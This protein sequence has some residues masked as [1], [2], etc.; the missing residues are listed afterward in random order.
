MR[1]WKE[2]RSYLKD[3][4]NAENQ[5]RKLDMRR[6]KRERDELMEIQRIEDRIQQEKIRLQEEAQ[7]RKLSQRYKS[8]LVKT[9]RQRKL[10]ADEQVRVAKEREE[11]E[12]ILK[13][14]QARFDRYRS[15]WNTVR[16][17]YNTPL[18]QYL[19]G[20]YSTPFPWQ[21]GEIDY[22][23][24]ELL[25]ELEEREEDVLDDLVNV[26]TNLDKP[27]QELLQKLNSGLTSHFFDPS[28]IRESS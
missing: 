2:G 9:R 11:Q 19:R 1:R 5:R 20:R 24:L 26:V 4:Q 22:R 15:L 28:R 18:D 6:E 16:P 25:E 13:E 14:K 7:M 12:R 8:R 10:K 21:E 17:D 23:R 3:K 27:T